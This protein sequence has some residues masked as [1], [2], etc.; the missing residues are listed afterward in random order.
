V[1]FSFQ[2]FQ[3]INIANLFLKKQPFEECHFQGLIRRFLMGIKNKFSSRESIIFSPKRISGNFFQQE[4]PQRRRLK[5][6]GILHI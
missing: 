2:S 1:S 3:H 6:L 4:N 5:S